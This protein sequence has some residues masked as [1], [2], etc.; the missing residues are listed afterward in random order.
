MFSRKFQPCCVIR[1]KS[2]TVNFNARKAK[3]KINKTCLI[4]VK[5]KL[6]VAANLRLHLYAQVLFS[7]RYWF[8]LGYNIFYMLNYSI[9]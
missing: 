1:A 4:K 5:H 3:Y 9:L 2:K 7:I 8:L 6:M